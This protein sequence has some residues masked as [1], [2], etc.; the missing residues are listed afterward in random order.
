MFT[1]KHLRRAPKRRSRPPWTAPA[2]AWRA[3]AGPRSGARKAV[4]GV[5]RRGGARFGARSRVSRAGPD[6]RQICWRAPSN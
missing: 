4:L 3:T 6:V 1:S 5:G 2:E